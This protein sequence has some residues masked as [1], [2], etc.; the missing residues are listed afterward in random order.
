MCTTTVAV[1]LIILS[2]AMDYEQCHPHQQMPEFNPVN[3]LLALGTLIFSY[4]GHAAFPSKYRVNHQ[5]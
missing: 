2:A 5:D 4:G 3:Y 1:C